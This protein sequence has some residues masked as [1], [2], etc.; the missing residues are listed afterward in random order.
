MCVLD[1]AGGNAALPVPPHH[2]AYGTVHGGS[3]EPRPNPNLIEQVPSNSGAPP[4][5]NAN[6]PSGTRKVAPVLD[7]VAEGLSMAFTLRSEYA[8]AIKRSGGRVKGLI[9]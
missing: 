7:I 9:A 2:R 3:R 4:P 8:S 6:A 5:D 1:R